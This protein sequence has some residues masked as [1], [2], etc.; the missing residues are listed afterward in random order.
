MVSVL[1]S[2]AELPWIPFPA[3]FTFLGEHFCGDSGLKKLLQKRVAVHFLLS[4]GVPLQVHIRILEGRGALGQVL[5]RYETSGFVGDPARGCSC[6]HSEQS[7]RLFE[8]ASLDG[9]WRSWTVRPCTG[10]R[11]GA[12]RESLL[13]EA[14]ELSF[15]ES[16]SYLIPLPS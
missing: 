7:A 12:L 14:S 16:Q 5:G 15:P 3:G 8:A 11:V 6:E 4:F 10:C 2:S 1:I 9:S 13:Q